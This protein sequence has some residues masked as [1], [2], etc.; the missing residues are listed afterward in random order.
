MAKC[1]ATLGLVDED[2][3]NCTR[4]RWFHGWCA[5]I[6]TTGRSVALIPPTANDKTDDEAQNN[7][8][9]ND[10]HRYIVQAPVQIGAVFLR[11]CR[12]QLV[13][14]AGWKNSR[15]CCQ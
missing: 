6:L 7:D 11:Q 15:H 4:T 10:R 5:D 3:V 8:S 1:K 13:V 2:D 14:G 9:A 12:E